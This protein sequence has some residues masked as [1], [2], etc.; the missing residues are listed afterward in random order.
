MPLSKFPEH[1][2]PQL[3]WQS[4]Q[5]L[6]RLLLSVG[7]FTEVSAG[8]ETHRVVSPAPGPMDLFHLFPSSN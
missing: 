4:L 3:A 1:N 7:E 2:S 6:P 5:Y 8:L